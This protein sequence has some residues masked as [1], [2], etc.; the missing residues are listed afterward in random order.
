MERE[1]RALRER[2]AGRAGARTDGILAPQR[3]LAGRT[4]SCATRRTSAPRSRPTG[5]GCRSRPCSCWPRAGLLRPQDLAEPLDALRARHGLPPDPQLAALS[6]DLVLS[7]SRRRSAPPS[8]ALRFAPTG[9]GDPAARST[10]RSGTV[11]NLE[12]G[13][14]SA[15]VLEGLRGL[16]VIVTVGP[17][18]DPAELG[19]QP[20]EVRVPRYIPQARSSPLPR[21]RLARRLGNLARRARARAA[22]G[23]DPDGRRPAADA[24]RAAALGVARVLDAVRATPDD[25]RAAVAEVLKRPSY[26][27]RRRRCATSSPRCLRSSAWWSCSLGFGEVDEQP[28]N[29]W[30]GASRAA[31]STR[32]ASPAT[33]ARCG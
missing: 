32:S 20:P 11:F 8:T 6:G 3:P 29:P 17:Q 5:S 19:P 22:D 21:R 31:S 33:R 2:F 13:D 4:C 9:H 1:Y 27:W 10:S 12:S 14:L 26:G 24:E 25:V 28:A 30:S 15:R 7:P 16:E 23:P 18:I